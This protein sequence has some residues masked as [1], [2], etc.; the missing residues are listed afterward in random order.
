M[1]REVTRRY[2]DPLDTLWIAA[3]AKMGLTIE[4]TPDAFAS[5]DGRG[6]LSIGD[7]AS[8]D[9]DDCLAQ[10]VFHEL[11][12]SLVE[13][14]ESFEVLDWGLTNEDARD[15][16]REYATLRVQ[17]WL[18][19]RHGLRWVLAPTTDHRAFYDGLGPDSL[20]GDDESARL[21]RVA[22]TRSSRPP[23]AP[24]LEEALASTAQVVR[25]VARWS[26]PGSLFETL[27][28]AR[29]RHPA[30]GWRHPQA[31]GSCGDCAWRSERCVVTEVAVEEDW[32]ACEAFVA[33]LECGPCGACCREGFHVVEVDEED[34]FVRVH[35]SMLERT[36]GRLQ[37]PRVDGRCLPLR[38]DGVEEPF[39]CA[40]YEDRPVS[41][42]DFERGG[43]SCLIARRRVGLSV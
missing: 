33:S 30:G 39:T 9:A 35:G 2:A 37:L 5:T 11:C 31:R 17:A 28:D 43:E 40:L 23:W 34:P 1:S 25:G 21:A 3:A 41:C 18:A 27:E 15:V 26:G 42:R 16:S 12:H 6:T 13:G 7:P 36:H 32:P 14:P 38:G 8:L 10:I 19:G 20:S 24:H 4:R 29:E 22:L